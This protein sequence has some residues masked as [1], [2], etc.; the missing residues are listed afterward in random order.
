M[1]LNELT[2]RL[3]FHRAITPPAIPSTDAVALPA[4]DTFVRSA[5]SPRPMAP[6]LPAPPTDPLPRPIPKLGGTD[7]YRLRAEDFARRH[8]DLPVPTYYLGYGD[9]Y[10]NRF[11]DELYPKLS[12]KGQEW[13][14]K[15]RLNLQVAFEERLKQD[16]AA[17]DALE[18]DDAALSKFAYETHPKAYLDAGLDEL[19]LKDLV[20]IGLT[21]DVGDLFSRN[22]IEQVADTAAALAAEKARDYLARGLTRFVD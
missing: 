10:V 11:T 13:L 22:G 21:P 2:R 6:T 14:V 17:F 19:P 8:P 7:Y 16:P 5:R 15:A 12:P 1:R 20:Q 4:R 18:R 9:K 3:P